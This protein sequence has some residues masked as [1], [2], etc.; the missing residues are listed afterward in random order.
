M[1]L[2]GGG[3]DSSSSQPS[4]PVGNAVGTIPPDVISP[5]GVGGCGLPSDSTIVT[6][7]SCIPPVIYPPGGKV[8]RVPEPSTITP[9]VLLMALVAI[10]YRSLK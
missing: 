2:G 10:Q 8:D 5:P 3:G 7:I 6:E 1:S 4:V 9:F